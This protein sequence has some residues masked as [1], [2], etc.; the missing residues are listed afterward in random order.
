[1]PKIKTEVGLQCS[2]TSLAILGAGV[3]LY[4]ANQL[5]PIITFSNVSTGRQEPPV[6]ASRTIH[7][8]PRSFAVAGPSTWNSLLASL[9][10]CHRPSAFWRELKTELFARAYFY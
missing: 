6:P 5:T 2:L 8:G 10:N 3:C 4:F 1:M 9:R 7:Y